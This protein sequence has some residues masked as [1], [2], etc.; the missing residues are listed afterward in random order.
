MD[1]GVNKSSALD[2][3]DPFV[4]N[5]AESSSIAKSS[6]LNPDTEPL[7]HKLEVNKSVKINGKKNKTSI[8]FPTLIYRNEKIREVI[9]PQT[10]PQNDDITVVFKNEKFPV[11]KSLLTDTC[12]Y[13]HT[14]LNPNFADCKSDSLGVEFDVSVDI[15][16]QILGYLTTGE[17]ELSTINLVDVTKLSIF[18]LLDNLQ[19][20]CS[21]IFKQ[22]IDLESVDFVHDFADEY[23]LSEVSRAAFLFKVNN[24]ET[25]WK[26]G[27]FTNWKFG[28]I[29]EMLRSDLVVVTEEKKVLSFL[30]KW[31]T[32]GYEVPVENT[33]ELLQCLRYSFLK[34]LSLIGITQDQ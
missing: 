6:T 23:H 8:S 16:K 28:Y 21:D 18:L 31:L 3:T 22:N 10:S 9:T 33:T 15:F 25:I 4:S 27:L 32:A 34:K 20:F 14:R 19:Q 30:C 5:T 7:I 29:R 17:I 24:F 2:I 13:F 11:S 26:S 1:D 12:V